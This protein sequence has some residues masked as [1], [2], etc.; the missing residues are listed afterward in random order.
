MIQRC[1]THSLP[2]MQLHVACHAPQYADPWLSC[3]RLLGSMQQVCFA[4]CAASAVWS[5]TNCRAPVFVQPKLTLTALIGMFNGAL[6]C[7]IVLPRLQLRLLSVWLWLWENKTYNH[8]STG[9]WV[10]CLE[11]IAQS[12]VMQSSAKCGVWCRCIQTYGRN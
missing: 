4:I 6:L 7:L 3:R 8:N 5:N 2:N 9:C 12:S 11:N 1:D 10:F